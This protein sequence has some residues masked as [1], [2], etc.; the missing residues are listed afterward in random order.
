MW[1]FLFCFSSETENQ[2][3]NSAISRSFLT[4]PSSRKVFRCRDFLCKFSRH[5][6]DAIDPKIVEVRVVFAIFRQFEVLHDPREFSKFGA[7][8]QRRQYHR[9]QKL[10]FRSANVSFFGCFWLFAAG[11]R[12]SDGRHAAAPVSS[13]AQEKKSLDRG[14]PVWPPRSNAKYDGLGGSVGALP[15]Q[16]N[17]GG[18][19]GQ[20]PP[21]QKFDFLFSKTNRQKLG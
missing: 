16:L 6:C 10:I 3:K 11:G 12:W 20:R 2:K 7:R 19:G 18:S 13:A 1:P 14:S 21:S 15:P 9:R 4:F 5:R 17:H 8:F